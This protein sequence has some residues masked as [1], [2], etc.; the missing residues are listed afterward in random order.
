M[1][2]KL[3]GGVEQARTGKPRGLSVDFDSVIRCVSLG[4]PPTSAGCQFHLQNNTHLDV[5]VR[6]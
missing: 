4:K 3:R 6:I 5:V 1:D 2:R